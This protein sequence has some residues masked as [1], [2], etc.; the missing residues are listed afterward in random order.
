MSKFNTKVKTEVKIRS[1]K[2]AT[3]NFEDGLAFDMSAKTRLYSRVCT[4]MMG[5]DKFYQT[6]SDHDNEMVKDIFVVSET[7]PEFVLRLA[8]YVR[9]EMYLR[10]V[11][12]MMLAEASRIVNCKPFIKKWA[13][14][15]I[16]RAD[17]LTEV[18]SYYMNKYKKPFPNSLK[19][20]INDAMKNFDEYQFDKYDRKGEFSFRDV[21]R[22]THPIPEN[23]KQED[24]Y[25]YLVGRD[26]KNIFENLPM[27]DAKNKL[28]QKKKFDEESKDL[29]K[30]AHATW[31]VLVSQFGNK[32]EV[33]ETV[34][35]SLGYMAVLRNLR[36]FIEK[37]V[38][39]KPVISILT[40]EKAVLRSKQFPFRFFSAYK[41][42]EKITSRYT[43]K[44]L[45]A[46]SDAL[47]ISCKNIPRMEGVTLICA[48][49]SGSMDLR[50]SEKSDITYENIA[51]LL[52]CIANRCCE[53]SIFMIFGEDVK[54]KNMNLRDSVLTNVSKIENGEVG[55]NTNG[56]KCIQYLLDNR[57]KVDR[58]ILISDMQLYSSSSSSSSGYYNRHGGETFINLLMKY[59]NTINP[60]VYCYSV[61]LSGYG[62][63]QVPEDDPRSCLI[64]G[65]NEKFL[66]YIKIFEQDKKS[67][68]DSISILEPK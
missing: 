42:V 59:R 61:D 23:S 6:G 52:G 38:D 7:D 36:N 60:K 13:P 54:V 30:K 26:P 41:Q 11:S 62:T 55:H 67:V 68:I 49:N 5:E 51:N 35:P 10:S 63:L 2:D 53:D 50:L 27:I 48:D 8:S 47:D 66:K 65:W 46:I 9:N 44:V 31:E 19:K 45:T 39:L 16:K 25:R 1:R 18:V 21:I 14:S 3:V 17:E 33:W 4:S 64:A 57:I 56:Y 28:T 34:I 37:E 15:I 40:N 43:S 22:L 24:L 12:I 58:V 32:K 29:A 20:G